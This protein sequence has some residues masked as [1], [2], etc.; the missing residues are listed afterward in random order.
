MLSPKINSVSVAEAKNAKFVFFFPLFKRRQ[1]N[2]PLKLLFNVF[3]RKKKRREV[4][5]AL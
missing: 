4:L 2:Y 5:F 1:E 3:Q